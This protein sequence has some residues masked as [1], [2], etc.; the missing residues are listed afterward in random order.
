M[1]TLQGKIGL[2]PIELTPLPRM[3]KKRPSYSLVK[4]QNFDTPVNR[5]YSSAPS[6][7][8]KQADL[9]ST[10]QDALNTG[11]ASLQFEEFTWEDGKGGYK[12]ISAANLGKLLIYMKT[13]Y[14]EVTKM[15]EMPPYLVIWCKET[16][17]EPSKRPFLIGGLLGVWL[18]E[19]QSLPR[20]FVG[21]YLGN[22]EIQLEIDDVY[23]QDIRPYHIPKTE[24]LFQLMRKGF[25]DALAISFISNEIFVELPE[26]PANEH[27]ERLKTCPGWFAH[28]GP[29]LFYH[30]GLRITGN[31]NKRLKQPM[32][33]TVDGQYDDSDYVAAQG[34]FQPGSMLCDDSGDMVTA[35]ILVKKGDEE[36][37]T[38]S[39]HC[40]QK[41]L[42]KIPEKM[43]DGQSFRVTQGKTHVGHVSSRLGNTD[44]GLATLNNGVDFR[45]QFMEMPGEPIELLHSD[46]LTMDDVYMM[47]SFTTGRQGGMLCKGKR[48]IT[49]EDK[50]KRVDRF[51]LGKPEDLPDVG[52]YLVLTQG[53]F[54]TSEPVA[55]GEPI[56]RAGCCG[57]AVVQLEKTTRQRKAKKS[58]SADKTKHEAGTGSPSK[59][60]GSSSVAASE[61]DA[62]ASE[63]GFVNSGK[64][65]GFMHWSDLQGKN[66]GDNIPRLLCYA[67]V[68]DPLIDAGWEVAKTTSKRKRSGSEE[69]AKEQNPKQ[70]DS[71]EPAKKQKRSDPD[72]SEDPFVD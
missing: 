5:G 61:L 66:Q 3:R 64:I 14:P 37:L 35:G 1:A 30:N 72:N 12:M 23:S 28:E 68:T 46:K 47:D 25:P 8:Q 59:K 31:Q 16:T 11:L 17:S 60:D 67:E 43:G 29:S 51:L 18:T 33:E 24:T 71:E 32:L 39:I 40:W 22:L 15:D 7:A 21:G 44:I 56:I 69:P 49:C 45:N 13:H 10:D 26:L 52:K 4:N 36:R 55:N 70:T 19:G 65:G 57:S 41:E 2:P 34:S 53:I 58:K 62:K 63:Q 54:A 50:E 20:E 42:D 27:V 38:V 48:V 9:S 6:T